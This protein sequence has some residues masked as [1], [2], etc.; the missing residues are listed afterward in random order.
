[1]AKRRRAFMLTSYISICWLMSARNGGSPGALWV[2]WQ[3]AL[4]QERGLLGN[5]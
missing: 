2:R 3:G 4:G 5:P 1:M